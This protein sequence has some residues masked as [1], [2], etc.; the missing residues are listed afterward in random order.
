MA[1]ALK[2][3]ASKQIYQS[4]NQLILNG[5]ET[6]FSQK[7]NLNNRWVILAHKIPWDALAKV[8]ISQMKNSTTGADGI[9]PRVAI[10]ALI[11]KHMC[12]L[13][14]RE[15]ILQIQEN[16]YMQ[17][18]IGYSSFSNEEPF[19]P[20]LFVDLRK[21]L[22]H[23]QIGSLNEMILKLSQ[24]NRPE[25]PDINDSGSEAV[26]NTEPLEEV[27][28]SVDEPQPQGQLITDATACPQD[29]S[30]PTDLNLLNDAREKSEE[31]IDILYNPQSHQ[32]KPRTY[33]KIARK[34]YLKTAQKKRKSTKE[35]RSAIRIQLCYVRRNIK[36]IH[37]L[38]DAYEGIPL[39]KY[40]YK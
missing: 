11:I 35:I 27:R 36:S 21:R 16:T 6:P 10:G 26:T 25:K 8:Y 14:D 32:N 22:G 28:D 17:Y 37:R 12:D 33:R 5:F 15:T 23:E 29:I 31:L 3:R 13:S 40:Q 20:S 2:S 24:T 1:K 7:L 9:N 34:R 30:Y 19:D 18:F 39:N 38:L 4:P